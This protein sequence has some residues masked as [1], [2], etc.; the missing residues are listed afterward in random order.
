M[1]PEF[2]EEV[3][4]AARI[5]NQVCFH[6]PKRGARAEG[7]G[8]WEPAVVPNNPHCPP[9]PSPFIITVHNDI[10][11]Q[12]CRGTSQV[13]G[14]DCTKLLLLFLVTPLMIPQ[15]SFTFPFQNWAE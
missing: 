6:S 2:M 10:S 1:L 11:R 13:S 9:H 8:H 5:T 7:Q 12:S 4:V 15:D 14:I 3:C